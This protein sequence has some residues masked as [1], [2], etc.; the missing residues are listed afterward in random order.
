VEDTNNLQ[1]LI[2]AQRHELIL[3][4]L[5]INKIASSASLSKI[6]N[7]SESTIRRDLE[8]LDN[9]GVIERTRGGAILSQRIRV[10][11]EYMQ[12]AQQYIDEKQRIG[13]A[14]AELI[15]EGDIVFVNS[16]TTAAQVIKHIHGKPNLTIITNNTT[17]LIDAHDIDFE[18][19]LLGGFFLPRSNAVIGPF[20]IDNVRNVF[21][22]KCIIG[23]DGIS[24]RY[25]CTVPTSAEAEVVRTMMENTQGSIII[26]SDHSKWG[27]VS[28][29]R[30]ARIDQINT[31]VTD[32]NLD[33]AARVDLAARSVDV[34][35]AKKEP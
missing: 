22:T 5:A 26:V 12:R 24:I 8:I 28:N 16:G 35:I 30:V 19:A 34:I 7:V 15:K 9:Q 13:F 21:A 29:Y 3:K 18:L 31:F 27:S 11:T 2:P 17:A 33:P 25:G 23:V 6:L 10:E 14:T 4:H 1:S 32:E 20:A